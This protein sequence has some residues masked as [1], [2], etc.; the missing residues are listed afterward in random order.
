MLK[1]VNIAILILVFP[2]FLFCKD[3]DYKYTKILAYQP[4][5]DS[6][7]IHTG[8]DLLI[9]NN[10]KIIKKK[11]IAIVCNDGSFDRNGSHIL[12]IFTDRK[13]LQL[14]SIIQ[15]VEKVYSSE[16]S[17][18]VIVADSIN[19][20]K[21]VTISPFQPTVFRKD[22]NGAN[23]ILIDLQN[24]GIRYENTLNVLISLMNLSAKTRI[25][26]VLLDRPNPITASITEGPLAANSNLVP[27]ARIPWRYGLTFG[28]LALLIN[29]EPWIPGKK[30]A[31]LY[32]IP[33]VNYDRSLWFDQTGLPW[34]IP[35][36]EI[37]TIEMLLSYCTTC[38]FKYSNVSN[39]QSSLF[40]WEVGGAPWISGPVII[41]TLN[42]QELSGVEFSL[43]TFVPGSKKNVL[44]SSQYIGQECTGIRI[45][46][47]NRK[48]YRTSQTGSYLLGI[49]GQLYPRHFR[50]LNPDNIDSIFGSNEYRMM[51]ELGGDVKELSPVW[52]ARLTEYQKLREQYFLYKRN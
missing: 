35:L 18:M 19:P 7:A 43:A 25:P 39:G 50:W 32:L 15:V 31:R 34:G 13:D 17:G 41:Q 9:Q 45:N 29:E 42:R 40:P 6:A 38:F 44:M 2:L 12:D 33:M 37:Y 24:I 27:D 16:S 47:M 5:S 8:L 51:V 23:L 21:N 48:I 36:D 30:G 49:I 11:K 52:I 22:L 20:V 1:N 28:E 46:I 4:S 14:V 3:Q 26:L 10:F